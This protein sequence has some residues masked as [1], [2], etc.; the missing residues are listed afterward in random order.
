VFVLAVMAVC[1]VLV[2]WRIHTDVG[3]A[4]LAFVLIT[5]LAFTMS[6]IGALIGMSVRSPEVA[7]TAGIVWLFPVTFVS[8]AFVPIGGMP[9]WLQTIANWNPVS[10]FVSAARE[11][12]GNPNP[13]GSGLPRE[14]PVVLSFAWIV[15]LLGIFV[16]LAV[17]KYRIATSR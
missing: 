17:R 15:V 4:L 6:W 8:N 3:H 13:F 14:H 5:L 12:F 1:G 9:G 7:S 10:T 16:P 11:L 2:G